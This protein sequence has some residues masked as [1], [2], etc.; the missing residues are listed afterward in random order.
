MKL[1]S[2]DLIC[3]LTWMR[4]PINWLNRTHLMGKAKRF[5]TSGMQSKAQKYYAVKNGRETGI[6]TQWS[7]V[8]PHINGY[9]G[10]L[11]KSFKTL[12]EAKDYL[13]EEAVAVIQPTVKA[14]TETRS[15]KKAVTTTQTPKKTFDV[16]AS[17]EPPHS[18]K[19]KAHANASNT[20]KKMK[21]PVPV[22]DSSNLPGPRENEKEVY[23]DGSSLKN[24]QKGAAAGW[25][26]YFGDDSPL[27]CYGKIVGDQ[28][29]N[30]GELT[31]ILK[32][33]DKI[34]KSRSLNWVIKSDSEYAIKAVTTWADNWVKNEWKTA[35]GKEVKNKELI[36]GIVHALIHAKQKGY[37]IR[38]EKVKGH[39]FIE[40]NEKADLLARK[41]AES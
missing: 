28:T 30:I 3:L 20:P 8:Q 2:R 29:N 23:T 33:I 6:F 13:L 17:L 26:V 41:G 1:P 18:K 14:V 24:G 12:A 5:S 38:F 36:E 34:L 27:N 19:A 16:Q 35:S 21:V 37:N 39:S 25:G 40:G 4:A 22:L 9:S 32:A 31:A 10:A 15:P 7:D 11:H